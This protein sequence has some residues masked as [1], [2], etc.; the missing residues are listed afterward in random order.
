MEY[1]LVLLFLL[2]VLAFATPDNPPVVELP[3]LGKIKGDFGKSL[4]GR[5]FYSFEGVPYARPPIGEHRFEPPSPV[6]PWVGTWEAKTIYKC[7]Q[8]NQYTPPGQDYVIGDEDCLY[9]N[10]YTPNLD[11]NAN[12]DVV[13]YIHGGAFMFNWGGLHGPDYLLDENV[14]L[15]N[16]NYRL[17]PLGFLST[18][19]PVVPGNNGAKDQIFALEFIKQHVKYFGGNPDSVTIMGMSAGGASVHFHYL[20]P[21]SRGLFH[22]GISQSGT[23]LDP[24][25]LQEQPLQKA[26]K[27][28]T[29][30][31][32]RSKDTTKMIACLKKRPAR[33][34]VASV[35]TFQP[36]LYTPFSPFGLVVDPWS[37]DPVLPA[38]P[39]TIIKD[40][41]VYDVPWIASYTS[42]EGLY[43]AAD[44]YIDEQYLEDV[45]TRWNELLP[46]ILDYNYTVDP[47][48]HDQV[49]QD[50]RK[51]YLKDVKVSRSTFKDFIPV[52]SDRIF[53][54]GI[55]K[56]ALLQASVTKSPVYSYYFT[57]RGAHSWSEYRGGT[58]EDFGASH[59]DDTVY[60]LKVEAVD[61][62]T[63]EKDRD[64][65]K[66]FT[67][68][69]TS[70]AKE[71]KPGVPVE[72]PPV[73]KDVKDPF[74][75]LQIDSPQKLSVGYGVSENMEF[76][77]S[78]PIIENEKLVARH[79]KDEL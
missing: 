41:Q 53:V 50:I 66:L 14:V 1:L 27:L 38:H 44:F 35:K 65:I 47:K 28:A 23:T 45:E 57:Y 61:T 56:T 52:V 49:S 39:Y 37:P 73:S 72:W 7:I 76:W 16:L 54:I 68:L 5:S 48:L 79:A 36:W 18:K 19:D 4:N 67:K 62:T 32:C 34:I 11:K 78:L 9:L 24:W 33:Q 29:N 25:V 21:K 31:G 26:K 63:T 20:S 13:V 17:G 22:R 6:T 51:H 30:V 71:G 58:T 10:I 64:M 59:G 42:S 43:P 8:Y 69:V 46:F 2:Q 15:V 60:A 75:F 3:N 77:D 12:L 74:V 55:Q 70:F 40:K